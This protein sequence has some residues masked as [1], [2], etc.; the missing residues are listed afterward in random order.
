MSSL[1]E[2]RRCIPQCA[3]SFFLESNNCPERA[4]HLFYVF[5]LIYNPTKNRQAY[6]CT[7][8]LCTFYENKLL[9]TNVRNKFIFTKSELISRILHSMR[10]SDTFSMYRLLLISFLLLLLNI[11]QIHLSNHL[12]KVQN[13][14]LPVKIPVYFLYRIFC[15]QSHMRT[16]LHSL[17]ALQV[18]R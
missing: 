9:R 11:P 2:K 12:L 16:Y 6:L 1:N 10:K 3:P 13:R 7:A 14:L 5:T 15:P 4:K 17:Q 18:R 8:C